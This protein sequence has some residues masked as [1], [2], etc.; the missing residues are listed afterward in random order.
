MRSDAD[1]QVFFALCKPLKTEVAVKLVD[2]EKMEEAGGLVRPI[3]WNT[4]ASHVMPRHFGGQNPRA[5]EKLGPGGFK[6]RLRG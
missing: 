1:S 4:V 3:P 5:R 6:F 2:L